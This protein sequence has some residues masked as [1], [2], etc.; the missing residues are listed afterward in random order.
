MQDSA[1]GRHS[2]TAA[3]AVTVPAAAAATVPAAVAATVPQKEESLEAMVSQLQA[4]ND[5]L[6]AAIAA[7]VAAPAVAA[8]AQTGRASVL[9]MTYL[10]WHM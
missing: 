9:P 6:R 2:A 7:A 5:R 10:N 1:R 8:P 3:A 4:D